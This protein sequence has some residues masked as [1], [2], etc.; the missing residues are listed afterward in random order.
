MEPE[1]IPI[2][3]KKPRYVIPGPCSCHHILGCDSHENANANMNSQAHT[4]DEGQQVLPIGSLVLNRLAG[5]AE[6]DG[7][8]KSRSACR[9]PQRSAHAVN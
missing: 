1:S 4:T 6:D 3:Y 5:A 8:N 2:Y 9:T 7:A